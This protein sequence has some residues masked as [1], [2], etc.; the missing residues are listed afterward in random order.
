MRKTALC[1]LSSLLCLPLAA[2]AAQ[3]FDQWLQGLRQEALRKGIS[4]QTLSAALQGVRPIPRVIELDRKQPEG[5]MTFDEYYR[6][7]INRQRIDQGRAL[8]RKHRTELERAAQKYGVPANYI[9]A[10]W[11]I[12][13]NY[14]SN[15]GG[16][17]VVPALATLAHDGR[18]S[19]FFRSELI[20]ALKILDQGHITPENMKG[21]WA[22]A[23]GQNQFMPSSFHAF[24]V[25]GNND[26]R[27]DIWTSLP[28]VFASTANYLSKSGWKA[29][30][31]WGREVKIPQGFPESLTG[32]KVE[33]SLKEWQGMGI[34][35]PSGANLPAAP[36]IKASLV[37]PDGLKGRTFLAYDNYRVIM[38][39]NKST[40]FATSVGLLA[41]QIA[42]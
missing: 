27:R 8:Y 35:L 15:T 28:D 7:V 19:E 18:R 20:N 12:E 3:P 4:Q 34:T 29:D 1:L 24:A 9:V 42:Q 2:H 41:N 16:F 22:G 26:G 5:R 25:D 40:Y 36:G 17:K 32:L 14:G 23:M 10:L 38:K 21:S 31:R 6:K 30:E 33:K 37:A 11:G 13:T 39:W